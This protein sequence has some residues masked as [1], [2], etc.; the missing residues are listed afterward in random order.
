MR[1][2]EMRGACTALGAAYALLFV[3]LAGSPAARANA[4]E[5]VQGV[6]ARTNAMGGAGTASAVDFSATYY[7]PANL[8]RC[9]NSQLGVDIRHTLYNLEAEDASPALAGDPDADP[10]TD[11][12]YPEPKPLRDQTRVTM[13]F[14]NHLPFNLSFGMVFGI[15]LQNPMTLDQSTLNQQPHWLLYGEQLEALSIALGIAYS[16][17][18]ELSFGFGASILIHSTLSIN[19]EIEVLSDDPSEVIFQW[20]LQPTAAI[21][22]GVNANPTSWLHLG[23]AYRGALYHALLSQ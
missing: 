19:T 13:G 1:N 23:I 11:D 4:P 17:I 7:N 3:L 10:T 9:E 18:P 21:Y 16:P 8:S 2:L 5:D 22:V 14:C 6:G 12:D 20:N 15:G